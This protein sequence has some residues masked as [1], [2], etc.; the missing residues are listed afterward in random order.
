[1]KQNAVSPGHDLVKNADENRPTATAGN[2]EV[3]AARPPVIGMNFSFPWPIHTL[4]FI[5][6]TTRRNTV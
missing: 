2:S 6:R 1:M 4:L 5:F 3:T